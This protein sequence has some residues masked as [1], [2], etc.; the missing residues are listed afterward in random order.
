VNTDEQEAIISFNQGNQGMTVVV[1]VQQE[2]RELRMAL[3]HISW[4]TYEHVLNDHLDATSPRFTYD[5][6]TLEI[7]SPS[8]EHEELK[9]TM[10]AVADILAEE[11]QVE[12]KGLGSTTFRRSDLKKG[13]EPDSCFYIQNVEKIRGKKEINLFIDP[14][15]DL[16]IEI[17]ITSP[18]VNKLP[19]YARLGVPEIWRYDGRSAI[20]RRLSEGRYQA[21]EQSGVL[22]PLTQSVLT[23]FIEQSKVLTTLAWRRMVRRW[24]QHQRPTPSEPR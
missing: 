12:F 4:E 16:V 10:S 24:T 9:V 1:D 15:P 21:A 8:S 20:I 6:G 3:Q 17:E 18:V 7:M 2:T 11:W 22:P 23:D 5:Q 14:A 19:I 13:T